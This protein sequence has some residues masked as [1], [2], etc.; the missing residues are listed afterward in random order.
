MGLVSKCIK[1]IVVLAVILFMPG[2][3]P[4]GDFEAIHVAPTMSLTG[5]LD[6]K[7]FALNKMERLYQGEFKGPEGI[8]ISPSEPG[9]LYVTPQGGPVLKVSSNGTVIK[10]L[11][12]FAKECRDYWDWKNCGRPFGIRF[13]RNGHLLVADAYLGIFKIDVQ[14]G[15]VHYAT[16]M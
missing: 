14:S 5:P 2:V 13:D 7:E 12:R 9:F 3:P 16:N 6:P 11:K 1:T 15:I 10:P 4:Y 8:D